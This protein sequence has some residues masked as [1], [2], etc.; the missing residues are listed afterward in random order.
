MRAPQGNARVM[1]PR[2]R[3]RLD[4][5]G[6]CTYK[7]EIHVN[8]KDFYCSCQAIQTVVNLATYRGA[9]RSP[10][11]GLKCREHGIDIWLAK[12]SFMSNEMR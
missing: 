1:E 4:G 2:V 11:I 3:V 5:G 7:Q 9:C 12:H 8:T 10:D 6:P